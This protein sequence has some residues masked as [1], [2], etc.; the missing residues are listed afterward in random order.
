MA[1]PLKW[2]GRSPV[3]SNKAASKRAYARFPRY[4]PNAKRSPRTSPRRGAVRNPGGPEELRRPG[5]R[6]PDPLRQ[7]GFP[8]KYFLDGTSSLWLTGGLVGK[9]AA[10]FTSTASLHG[11]QE[12]TQLSM[13]LPLLHHGMLVL[14]IPT[15]NPPCWKPAAAARLTAPATSPAPMASAASMSTN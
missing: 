8:L 7:H 5:P 11:G 15:A 13:L 6:Q 9:P 4:P 1:L 10:V 14:G 2:P 3:A 12:T